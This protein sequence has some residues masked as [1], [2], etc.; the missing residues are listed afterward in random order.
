MSP[1]TPRVA[2][3]GWI[4]RYEL[5]H[6][7]LLGRC[8]E[9]VVEM[10][11]AF[12]E[13]TEVRGHVFCAWGKRG[14]AWLADPAGNIVDPTAA[15]FPGVFEY[16][17]WKPGDDVRVGKCM[18]CGEDIWRPVQTLDVEPKRESSCSSAC[19]AELMREFA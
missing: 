13:L 16:E 11:A 4:E 2:Y 8:R 7:G 1:G 5:E 9:A 19:E 12:P 17:A 18:N 3:A 15:Q 14:H 6:V 10:R